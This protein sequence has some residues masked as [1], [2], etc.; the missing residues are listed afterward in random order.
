MSLLV[1]VGLLAVFGVLVALRRNE[2]RGKQAN[3]ATVSFVADADGVTR[4]LADGREEAVRWDELREVEVITT[5]VG[6]H[7]DDGVLLVLGA[8]EE[9]GCLVPSAL[10]TEHG[11]VERVAALPGFDVRALSAAMDRPP[12]SRTSVWTR[13]GKPGLPQ[14]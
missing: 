6:V 4:R 14:G 3:A 2:R 1:V 9:R 11:V 10:A 12:P 7:K 5:K 13:P 8:D